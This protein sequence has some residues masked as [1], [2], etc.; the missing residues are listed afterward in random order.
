MSTE[1]N[2]EIVRRYI[3]EAVS[4]GHL[5]RTGEF[6]ADTYVR[7]DPSQPAEV[8]GLAALTALNARLRAP[9][10]DLQLTIEDLLAEGDKVVTRLVA[11]GTHRGELQGLAPTGRPVVATAIVIHRLAGG[12]IVEEWVQM[13]TLGLLQQLGAVPAPVQRP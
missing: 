12:K 4:Q 10:P 3:E 7:H 13:D 5:D 2:K 8:R 1:K 6:V 11:R 9:I